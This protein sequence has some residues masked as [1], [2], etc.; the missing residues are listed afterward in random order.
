MTTTKEIVETYFYRGWNKLDE[1]V[2][3]EVLAENIQFRGALSRRPKRGIAEVI[4]YIRACHTALAK[5]TC[6][7]NDCVMSKDGSRVAVRLT[8]RGVHRSSFFGVEASGHEVD[9]PIAAFLTVK[10]GRITEIWNLGDIDSLKNQI[11]AQQGD[12]S[13]FD[14]DSKK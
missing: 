2:L 8:V 6:V 14:E 4:S 3:K 9:V 1:K 10:D 7:I 11:G 5:Y 12:L 13:A